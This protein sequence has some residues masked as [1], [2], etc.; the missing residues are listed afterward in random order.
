M[1]VDAGSRVAINLGGVALADVARG[2]AAVAPEVPAGSSFSVAF[3]PLA[4]A[5]PLIRRR[6]PVR[7]HIG[8]GETFGT[9]VLTRRP[10]DAQ[11]VE[12]KLHLREAAATVAG[13]RFIL[14]RMSPKTVLGGG[15]I[16]VPAA[17]DDVP[18]SEPDGAAVR[19]AVAALGLAATPP[20]AI[21][22]A[23]N[24]TIDRTEELLADAV[25]EGVVWPLARPLAYVDAAF[26]DAFADRVVAALARRESDA[27]WMLGATSIA[28]AREFEMS[29]DLLVR[30]LA[31]A[32]ERG[33]LRVKS[34]YYASVD[35]TPQLTPEQAAL[36]DRLVRVDPAQPFVPAL[37]E[38]LVQEIRHTKVAGVSTAFDTL[39]ATGRLVRVGDHIYR[40]EQINEIRARLVRTLRTERRITAAR[41]RDV[42]GTSRKYIVP[43]LEYFD[44]AGVTVRDGD[45]RALRAY[46]SRPV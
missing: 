23:A 38:P 36:F 8:A 21:A 28:L 42:V 40:G 37:F 12:A 3:T 25:A 16:G 11:T 41:F 33:R 34:G 1:R 27:P 26:A 10:A 14:R 35:F 31:A 24:L 13:Q 7:V 45:Q 30:V 39:V 5:L 29:E 6:T 22:S 17:G 19:I 43:L 4:D 32:I 20:G 18:A 44:A 15:T 9:L 46:P 2:H